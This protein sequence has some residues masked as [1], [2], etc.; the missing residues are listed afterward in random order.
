MS[1]RNPLQA[2]SQYLAVWLVQCLQKALLPYDWNTGPLTRKIFRRLVTSSDSCCAKRSIVKA[3]FATWSKCGLFQ[4]RYSVHSERSITWIGSKEKVITSVKRNTQSYISSR[5]P[6]KL[7]RLLLSVKRKVRST[8]RN[9]VGGF[10][11]WIQVPESPRTFHFPLYTLHFTLSTCIWICPS[12]QAIFSGLV[13]WDAFES[14]E[15]SPSSGDDE[16]MR[17]WSRK[18]TMTV[19]PCCIRV[20]S[21]VFP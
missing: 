8:C 21:C 15:R 2:S 5:N 16:E 12:G 4:M 10:A 7:E 9:L 19:K 17:Q 13:K 20:R 11:K 1:K 14:A 6:A 18:A 3:T